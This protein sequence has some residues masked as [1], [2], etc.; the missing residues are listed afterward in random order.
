[1]R[2]SVPLGLPL[3]AVLLVACSAPNL[4]QAQVQLGAHTMLKVGEG[5]GTSP[6]VTAPIATQASGSSLIVF[7]AGYTGNLTPPID[8]YQN[9]WTELGDPV[10]YNGYGEAFAVTGY[11]SLLARGGPAHTVSIF[12]NSDPAGEITVPFIE[13]T[14]AGVLQELLGFLYAECC[15]RNKAIESQAIVRLCQ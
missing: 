5:D 7:N 4:T 12:K 15:T 1:M 13:V 6:A 10:F 8:T 3:G 14:N 9:V 2:I 11:V